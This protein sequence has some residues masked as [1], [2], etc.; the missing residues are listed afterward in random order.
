ML[1]VSKE[2]G[3]HRSA[4]NSKALNGGLYF[5]QPNEKHIWGA[6]LGVAAAGLGL[7]GKKEERKGAQSV[8]TAQQQAASTD[9]R[10]ARE[11][12]KS[13]EKLANISANI[14]LAELS[15]EKRKTTAG[16]RTIVYAGLGVAAVVIFIMVLRQ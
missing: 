2:K 9:L 15:V 4:F 7:M 1:I 14:R 5:S 3:Y 10:K 12:I 6:V 11:Q 8:A 13:N 16:Q